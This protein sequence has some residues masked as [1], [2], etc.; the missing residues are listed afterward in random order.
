MLSVGVVT[1]NG[2]GYYLDT[3]GSGVDDYYVRSDPGRWSGR[4]A[5]ELGLSGDVDS[6]AIDM[7]A[8]RRHP[9]TGDPLGGRPGKVVAFDLTFSA[10]KTV[11]VLGGLGAPG[12]REAVEAAHRAAVAE[13]LTVMERHGLRGRRGTAGI[14]QVATTGAVAAGFT[15]RT[16]RAGDPQLHTHLLVLNGARGVDGRWGA[17][18]GRRVFAWAKTAGYVYQAVLRAELTQRLGVAWSPVRNG[19]AELVGIP[20][21]VAAEFSQRRAQIVAHLARSGQESVRAAQTATL[22]TRPAKPGPLD[23]EV[24]QAVWWDRAVA[25]GVTAQTIDRTIGRVEARG[26]ALAPADPW[27]RPLEPVGFTSADIDRLAADLAG[28]GGLTE[29]RST[30]DRRHLIE[31]AAAAAPAGAHATDIDRVVARIARGGQ[32]VPTGTEHSLAGPTFTTADLLAAEAAVMELANRP[33]GRLRGCPGTTVDDT[34]EARRTLSAEQREMVARLCSSTDP[35]T[36]VIGRAGTG[37]TFALD[38]ARQAWTQAGIP[39]IGTALAA[40]TAQGLEAGT[41]IPSATV[42]QLLADMARPGLPPGSVLPLGGVVVVDEAGMVGTRKLARILAAAQQHGSRVVLVGDPRQLPEVEAGGAFAHLA[43][44]PG[45]LELT[46]N[47]RQTEAWERDAL[48]E[49]RH[50]DVP[51]AV[52]VY[53]DRERITLTATAEQAR[54]ALVA[55]WWAATRGGEHTLMMASSQADVDDLNTRARVHLRAAGHLGPDDLTAAGKG[56]AVG[57]QVLFLRNDRRLGVTNGQ[58]ATVVDVGPDGDLTTRPDHPVGPGA[59]PDRPTIIV[60][61]DYV[62]AGHVTH[63]YATTIHKAQGVTVDRAFLL[64]SD[65]LTREAGYVGLSRARAR[66]D[67][68]HVNPVPSRWEPTVEPYQ[69]LANQLGRSGQQHLATTQLRP[70]PPPAGLPPAGLP[71]AGLLSASEQELTSSQRLTPQQRRAAELTAAA[72]A[73][74]PAHLVDRLGPPPLAGPARTAWANTATVVE[75]YRDRYGIADATA[76]GPEVPDKDFTVDQARHRWH[77]EVA[78]RTAEHTLTRTPERDLGLGL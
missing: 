66:T 35:V 30:F 61:A 26:L 69:R 45:T 12:T 38:A 37:K 23:P 51:A 53:R 19:T 13:A 74:P 42:D 71:S 29:H 75:T 31:A 68:Y 56:F 77:A 11:S 70:G 8:G 43:T 20:E 64:G 17:L 50:G 7:I 32:L 46:T 6:E 25:L 41:G 58:R 14:S 36:V 78:L 63:G 3:V 54:D 22:I 21:P 16:S 40:R 15:H 5:R 2:L 9:G 10:P 48:A 49:V 55:D 27:S 28:P 62:T 73:D 24:Q 65:R 52:T 59:A 18:H 47:R 67:L 44:R 76:L 34:L 57:D 60:P 33:A 4:G 72:L 1:A 39:V